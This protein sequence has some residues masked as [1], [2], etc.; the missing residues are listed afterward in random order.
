MSDIKRA[1]DQ[2]GGDHYQQYEIEPI[3]AMRDWLNEDEFR[4]FLRSSALYYQIRYR[5]KNG[6]EDL[7]KAQ[8]F[9]NELVGF[10]QSLVGADH[11]D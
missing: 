10:E 6:I 4:G 3:M 9:L 7:K 8:W 2:V 5:D 11:N 1:P